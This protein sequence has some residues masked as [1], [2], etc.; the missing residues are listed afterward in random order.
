MPSQSYPSPIPSRPPQETLPIPGALH[1]GEPARPD[2]DHVEV[3]RFG[4]PVK[5]KA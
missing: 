4:V 5:A 1:S 3:D 2:P